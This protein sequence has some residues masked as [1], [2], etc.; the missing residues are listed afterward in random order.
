MSSQMS[1]T[2]LKLLART[3][4]LAGSLRTHQPTVVVA[5]GEL[6]PMIFPA[7]GPAPPPDWSQHQ[8]WNLAALESS[9]AEVRHSDQEHRENLVQLAELQR[10]RVDGLRRLQAGHRAL[11]ASFIGT[12]DKGS[13]ALVGLDGLAARG[14]LAAREQLREVISRLRDP[15]L[16]GLLPPP[17]AG[18]SS[19]DLASLASAREA[20]LDRYEATIE[21]LKLMRKQVVESR[22]RRDEA[23]ERNR[24]IYVNVGRVQE[25]LY[26][27]AGLG[28]LADHIRITVR[29]ARRKEDSS[30]EV[31][32]GEVEASGPAESGGGNPP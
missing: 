29:S 27:L 2:A 31:S 28:E 4:F 22:L 8:D 18:Q 1:K 24:Q 19:I 14:T 21:E 5:L 13:L 15:D 7:G 30:G 10:D 32:E 3:E 9:A 6:P 16:T 25:G 17:L 23:R 20:E 12:Y 11:R 26:R